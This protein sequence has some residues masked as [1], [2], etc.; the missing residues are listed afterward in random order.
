MEP[1]T[2]RVHVL[3]PE[4]QQPEPQPD[5]TAVHFHRQHLGLQRVPAA[6]QLRRRVLQL[7]PLAPPLVDAEHGP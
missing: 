4:L 1:V 6:E 7:Q 2:E 3:D 5:G